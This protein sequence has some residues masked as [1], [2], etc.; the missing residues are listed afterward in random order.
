MLERLNV[1][2]IL[3]IIKCITHLYLL[4]CQFQSNLC[5][6][7]RELQGAII[8]FIHILGLNVP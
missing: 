4:Y 8:V 3:N 6:I 7:L 2:C 5:C 1:H